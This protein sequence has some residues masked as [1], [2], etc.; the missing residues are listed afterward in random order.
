M[1][2]IV[3]E[4]PDLF[5]ADL[6]ALSRL[7]REANVPLS[8]RLTS[9]FQGMVTRPAVVDPFVV[10]RLVLRILERCPALSPT[11]TPLVWN[12]ILVFLSREDHDRLRPLEGLLHQ[13]LQ[14]LIY[15][16]LL[17]LKADTVGPV[18][19]HLLVDEGGDLAP[20]TAR[21]R[22]AFSATLRAPGE[23]EITVRIGQ[24]KG[25]PLL[26]PP[27]HLPQR[28]APGASD[29][30]GVPSPGEGTERLPD[31]AGGAVPGGSVAR[32]QWAGGQCAIPVGTRVVLGR[33][34]DQPQGSFVALTGASARVSRRQAW[35]E[36]QVE[37][38][39][40]GRLKDANPVV[41]NGQLL[42][43]GGSIAVDG[44]PVHIDLSSGDLGLTLHRPD[45]GTP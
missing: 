30:A 40:V 41:V 31:P 33:P 37:G 14:T 7:E 18:A 34:H 11:G 5:R 35:V 3:Q 25:A 6:A 39:Q 22:V 19:V 20:A 43:P 4:A 32:L 17:R 45:T 27:V 13:D 8:R 15:E 21:V 42:Q 26:T 2:P 28:P 36:P 38:A 24:Q 12:E 10:S 44:Y 9:L 29:P 16:K 23:G 1:D